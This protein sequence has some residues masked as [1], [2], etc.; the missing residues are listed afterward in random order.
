MTGSLASESENNLCG[1][2]HFYWLADQQ[3]R[4]ESPLPDT[5]CSSITQQQG[6][7][8]SFSRNDFSILSDS[9]LHNNFALYAF[10]PGILWISRK[11]PINY[12]TL[13]C[14]Y[15]HLYG[16]NWANRIRRWGKIRDESQLFNRFYMNSQERFSLVGNTDVSRQIA[17]LK[18]NN[19]VI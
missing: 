11:R 5:V 4:V 13:Q 2:L 6:T 14:S 15:I 12:V 17:T 1:A 16:G 10:Q 7:A 18:L 3:E 8:H 9:E 19:V